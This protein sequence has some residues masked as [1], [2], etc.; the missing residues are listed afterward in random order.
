[1]HFDQVRF[2]LAVPYIHINSILKVRIWVLC[3]GKNIR[4]STRDESIQQTPLGEIHSWYLIQ[5]QRHRFQ[6][7]NPSTTTTGRYRKF[8]VH[9]FSGED[10]HEKSWNCNSLLWRM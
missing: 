6:S 4:T 5:I 1:M 8:F 7:Y 9:G 2:L 3:S 10:W